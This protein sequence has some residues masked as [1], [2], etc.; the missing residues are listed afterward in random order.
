MIYSKLRPILLRLSIWNFLVR[1]M[2][3]E[4]EY[5]SERE[6]VLYGCPHV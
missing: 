6:H 4:P 3:N 5:G 1:V 2:R